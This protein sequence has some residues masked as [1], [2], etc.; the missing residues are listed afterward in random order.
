M[1]TA[2]VRHPRCCCMLAARLLQVP[3]PTQCTAKITSAGTLRMDFVASYRC[4]CWTH[5]GGTASACCQIVV[6][7]SKIS[8]STACRTAAAGSKVQGSS[9]SKPLSPCTLLLLRDSCLLLLLM[10]QCCCYSSRRAMLLLLLLHWQDAAPTGVQGCRLLVTCY[11]CC[12]SCSC[13]CDEFGRLLLGCPNF[14]HIATPDVE[15]PAKP[16]TVGCRGLRL[17]GC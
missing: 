5:S 16:S 14:M 7:C 15:M 10:V 6:Q 4:K 8:C 3:H 9:E 11:P 2:A 17:L 13:C 12:C 1:H